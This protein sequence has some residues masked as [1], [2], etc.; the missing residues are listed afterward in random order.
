MERP[1]IG[2]KLS[3]E[4]TAVAANGRSL[5]DDAMRRR[6]WLLIV[7][8]LPL[9]MM[10]VSCG[11]GS[12]PAS[13]ITRSSY[14]LSNA[15]G[16][17][18]TCHTPGSIVYV[19]LSSEFT[20]KPVTHPMQQREDCLLC[21]SSGA[22]F[23][24]PADH[25]PVLSEVC[26]TCH[27]SAGNP[28]AEETRSP[29]DLASGP[30]TSSPGSQLAPAATS[31]VGGYPITTASLHCLRCHTQGSAALILAS[32]RLLAKSVTHPL[33]QRQDC[34]LCHFTGSESPLPADHAQALSQAC[35]ACHAPA[36][37]PTIEGTPA[38]NPAGGLWPPAP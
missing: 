32:R 17:C 18:A 10:T 1:P 24:F 21:H 25:G 29:A 19:P 20:L 27:T 26:A 23:P 34:L 33:Q 2:A 22:K 28:A 38:P 31:T 14:A 5:R 4:K 12:H 37:I 9:V 13:S 11:S 30:T 8:A 7:T 6:E 16:H 15:T 3:L 36:E 35:V